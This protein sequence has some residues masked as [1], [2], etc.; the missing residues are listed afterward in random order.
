MVGGIVDKGRI[1]GAHGEKR[2]IAVCQRA[3]ETV[4]DSRLAAQMAI[5][6]IGGAEGIVRLR[7]VVREKGRIEFGI[8]PFSRSKCFCKFFT[9]NA[10]LP[11]QEAVRVQLDFAK[12]GY[13]RLVAAGQGQERRSEERRVGKE[14]RSRWSPYH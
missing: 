14:C 4:V 13:R 6:I 9:V 5:E 8:F 7:D 3:A 1:V 12:L 2:G 11:R 10:D